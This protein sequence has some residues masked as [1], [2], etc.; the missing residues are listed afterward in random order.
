M[1]RFRPICMVTDPLYLKHDTGGAAH[2]ESA[3]RLQA[4]ARKLECG[5]LAAALSMVAP[6]RAERSWITTCH[7]EDYLFRLEEAALSGRTFVDHPDNQICFDSFDIA[8]L[9][10]GAG[11]VGIDRLEAGQADLVFCNVRPPGH[12]AEPAL[13]FGF[14]LLNNAA[15]AARYWQS[16]YSRK[17]IAIIDWDAHHGNGIQTI[18][19]EDPDILYISIHEHPTFS[20]PG[21]GFAEECGRGPGVGSLLN[22]PLPPG[23]GDEM[24][25]QA[26]TDQVMPA[27]DR[28]QP[29]ALIVAAGFDGHCLD[30]MSGLAY[31][32]ELYGQLGG[33]MAAMA[34]KHCQGRVLSI[35]EGGYHLEALAASVEQYLMG[36]AG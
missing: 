8:Q 19:E 35:L 27:M 4:I 34:R 12:H 10:A 2:P 11:L 15:I 31:S 36:L 28:F 23:G 3:A 14:C 17:K 1:V 24:V 29:E 18:F 7:S 21:T 5:V 30:D 33:C 6:R 13:A 26:M 16:R 32:T 22:I 9:A 25:L 20:F